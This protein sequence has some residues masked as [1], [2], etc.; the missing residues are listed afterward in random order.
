MKNVKKTNKHKRNVIYLLILL[1]IVAILILIGIWNTFRGDGKVSLSAEKITHTNSFSYQDQD[2]GEIKK[3]NE[4]DYQVKKTSKYYI[5]INK[6][7]LYVFSNEGKYM[8]SRV[9]MAEKISI[10]TINDLNND[11]YE[12]IVVAPKKSSI[13]ITKVVDGKTGN[14]ISSITTYK[15][16]Y[17]NNIPTS[18][19]VILKNGGEVFIFNLDGGYKLNGI[20]FEKILET[21]SLIIDAKKMG[22]NLIVADLFNIYSF[23]SDYSKITTYPIVNSDFYIGKNYI[24]VRQDEYI[25]RQMINYLSIF[26]KNLNLVNKFEFNNK[27]IDIFSDDLVFLDNNNS[28][29]L[30]NSNGL[31]ES[32]VFDVNPTDFEYQVINDN[33]IFKQDNVIRKIKDGVAVTIYKIPSEFLLKKFMVVD[34]SNIATID[35][36]SK[37][38]N[39]LNGVSSIFEFNFGGKELTYDQ[40]SSDFSIWNEYPFFYKYKDYKGDLKQLIN[41]KKFEVI[42]IENIEDINNDGEDEFILKL[43]E[44]NNYGINAII[45]FYPKLGTGKKITFIPSVGEKLVVI[46]ETTTKINETNKN[47]KIKKQ[48]VDSL[49]KDLSD[50]QEELQIEDNVTRQN[51]IIQEMNKINNKI[52]SLQTEIYKLENE[53][54]DLDNQKS[55]IESPDLV[56]Q[57][58]IRK[59]SFDKDGLLIILSNGE[60]YKIK[61][62]PYEESKL[63]LNSYNQEYAGDINNDGITDLIGLKQDSIDLLDGK[64]LEPMWSKNIAGIIDFWRI[65]NALILQTS[66]GIISLRLSDGMELERRDFDSNNFPGFMTKNKKAAIFSNHY[67]VQI[68]GEKYYDLKIENLGI[69]YGTNM[70]NFNALYDCNKDGNDEV[71]FGVNNKY[72]ENANK[73]ILYCID[74][75][76][77]QKTKEIVVI[78]SERQIANYGKFGNIFGNSM[79]G[80]NNYDYVYSESN[81]LIPLKKTTN[82]LILEFGSN[83]NPASYSLESYSIIDSFGLLTS[84]ILDA[85][86]KVKYV[87]FGNRLRIRSGK[88]FN[89]FGKEIPINDNRDL[90]MNRESDGF[91]ISGGNNKFIFINDKLVTYSDKNEDFVG[92]LDEKNPIYLLSSMPEYEIFEIY[93][94]QENLRKRMSP[95][96]I[97]IILLEISLLVIWI[98]LKLKWKK[99]E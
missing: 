67:G 72:S 1:S 23:N 18:N 65:D 74:P 19:E 30:V 41:N 99:K 34:E 10:E 73:I 66:L 42:G 43:G 95:I 93:F 55:N 47:L 91:T 59:F 78:D 40:G 89:S 48:E 25:N 87:N 4:G 6:N 85:E 77:G 84:L 9:E 39:I 35:E 96:P 22:E 2:N 14:L 68:F 90:N 79:G 11:G 57:K 76:I 64:T 83:D 56:N 7:K 97:L 29:Y 16:T 54:I 69:S 80:L 82:S 27:I 58:K 26:D 5:L 21:E 36:E 15:E 71:V 38:L 17:K 61:Y 92:T 94:S 46:N 50:Y 28:V 88:I 86:N 45:L 75:R 98:I 81:S 24:Y 70:D 49:N 52:S 60:T 44:K 51:F 32:K 20:N 33:F 13:P 31:K 37:K 8:W 12:E 3:I 62:S 53:K 63:E